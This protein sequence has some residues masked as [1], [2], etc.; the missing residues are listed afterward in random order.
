ME[1]TKITGKGLATVDWNQ[2]FDAHS[3]ENKKPKIHVGAIINE[4]DAFFEAET[5]I[6][7]ESL[8]DAKSCGIIPEDQEILIKAVQMLSH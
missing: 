4:I 8:K 5:K 3:S 7:R 2:V 1:I 6:R